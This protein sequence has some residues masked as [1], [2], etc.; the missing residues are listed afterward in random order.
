MVSKKKAMCGDHLLGC[1]FW[2][3]D[4]RQETRHSTPNTSLNAQTYHDI[5]ILAQKQ[6]VVLAQKE[7]IVLVQEQGVAPVQKQDIALVQKQHIVLL[8]H[9]TLCFQKQGV[10]LVQKQDMALV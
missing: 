7:G 5:S 9:K 10:V 2:G 8:E 4:Q 1:A 3:N 6:D